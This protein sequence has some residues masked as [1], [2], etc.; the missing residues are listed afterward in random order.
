MFLGA[1]LTQGMPKEDNIV[2]YVVNPFTHA[3][4]LADICAA[5]SSLFQKYVADADTQQTRQLNDLVLQIVPCDFVMS[6]ES[7]VV[8]P[9][10]RYLSLALEVYSRC[11]PKPLSTS[12]A[13][14]APPVLLADSIPRSINFRLA[15]ENSSPLQ[16]G[17]CLH[18]AFSK[19][20]DQRWVS[21]AWSDTSGN[22]QRNISYC[23]RFRNASASSSLSD[24]RNAI[25]TA[26]KEMLDKAR[27]RWRIMLAY[28]DTVDQEEI[29]SKNINS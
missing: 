17:R 14:C 29:D 26:T 5:F 7:L 1:V 13:G 3:T 18:I 4:A 2:L 9:Q 12:L 16:D 25:W 20:L 24:V 23:L 19:S 28:T 22:L 27:A 21:V 8:P 6:A 11:P 10:T 15:P